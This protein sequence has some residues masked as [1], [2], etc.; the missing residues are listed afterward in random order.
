MFENNRAHPRFQTRLTGRLLSLDG[1]CNYTCAIT[2]VSEGG[3]KVGTPEW[4]VIPDKIYLCV[5]KTGDVFEC[6]VRWRRDGEI[7]MR[8]IDSP[9]RASRRALLALCLLEPIH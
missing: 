9:A 1:R 7:G 2:D 5:V 3:A 8:I 4:R 6:D